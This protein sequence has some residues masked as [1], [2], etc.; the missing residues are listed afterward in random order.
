MSDVST[1]LGVL[2][3]L[4]SPNGAERQLAEQQVKAL[5]VTEGKLNIIH[6]TIMSLKH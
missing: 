3:Q 4:L 2:R 1:L 6:S 5:E